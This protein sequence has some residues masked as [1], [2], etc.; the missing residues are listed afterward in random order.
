[1]I[2]IS[3][4]VPDGFEKVCDI[5]DPSGWGDR[6]LYENIN[7]DL[8]FSEHRSWVYAIVVSGDIW[9]IGETGN[10]LGIRYRRGT[11]SQ[12]IPGSRSR[13]G[14]YRSGDT[15]DEYIREEL[16]PVIQRGS[17][18]EFWAKQCPIAATEVTIAGVK[19][20]VGSAIHKELEVAYLD[21][22]FEQTGTLPLLNKSRK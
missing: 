16:A 6:W 8:M 2:S 10:P 1:M 17:R 13:L 7:E 3:S 12:P 5:C 11:S 21:W 14:R 19:E 22:I 15:T 20:Q 4:V 18:V 9:K